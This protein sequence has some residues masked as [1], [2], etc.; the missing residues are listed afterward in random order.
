[1]KSSSATHG[2]AIGTASYACIIFLDSLRCQEKNRLS[3]EID[4]F[5]SMIIMKTVIDSYNSKQI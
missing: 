1:M 4:V 2:I 3:P 5:R